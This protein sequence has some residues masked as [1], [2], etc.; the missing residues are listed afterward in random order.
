MIADAFDPVAEFVG[1]PSTV[2]K[3]ASVFAGT[4]LVPRRSMD[5]WQTESPSHAKVCTEHALHRS[6]HFV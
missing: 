5:H 2:K 1:L 6:S 4:L 3:K